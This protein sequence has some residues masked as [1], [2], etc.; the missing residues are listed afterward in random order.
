MGA[1]GRIYVREIVDEDKWERLRDEFYE[2]LERYGNRYQFYEY[3][4]FLGKHVILIYRGDYGECF[5]LAFPE[6]S[7]TLKWR[8]KSF[9]RSGMSEE[10]VEEKIYQ[11]FPWFS[12]WDKFKD[13]FGPPQSFEVW[14]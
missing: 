1:D 5:Y 14:T 3:E 11:E 2:Y 6:L 13:V 12:E 4:D 8:R 9:R 10:E 7:Y